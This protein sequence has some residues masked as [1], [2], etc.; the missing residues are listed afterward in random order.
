MKNLWPL[1]CISPWVH[2]A[3]TV[4]SCTSAAIATP[5]VP[6]ALITNLTAD[7]VNN[8][9]ISITGESN[10]W[11]AQ[12]ITVWLP[13]TGWNGIFLGVG[14]GGFLAGSPSSLAPAVQ[15]GYAAVS[16]DAGHRSNSTSNA[17][18]W[19]LVSNG[20]VN[21]Y[22]LLDFGSRSVHDMTV[23][24]KAV[25]TSFYGSAPN[26]SYWQGCS[27][28][29]RQG[30]MEAQRYPD[31]YDGIVA[32]APAIQWNDLQAAQQWPFTVMINEGYA[33][34]QC[35]FDAVNAA[36]IAACDGL[37][38]LEDGII[39]APGLCDFNPASLVG[40]TYTCDSDGSQRQFS[41]KTATVV[42]KI[43]QGP[44]TANG[45]N[46]WYGILP[47]TNFSSLAPTETFANGTTIPQPFAISDNWYRNFLFKDPNY[48]TSNIT[49]GQFP[50][51][52]HQSHQE[53]DSVIGTADP[54]LSAYKAR[55]GKILT[56]QGLADY[57]IMPNGTMHYYD[58]VAALD[59]MVTDFYRV[60]FAPGVG[61]CGGGFGYVPV[62][63][64]TAL[65]RWVE[66]GTAPGVLAAATSFAVNGTIRTQNLCPY[67]SVS[68]YIG[69]GDPAQAASF[70]CESSF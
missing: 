51:L 15:R 49:Y 36:A 21:Q 11:P 56:W 29:G 47:G 16:T 24:G 52:T 33:P 57:L 58:Q 45:S 2:A 61:H 38:G 39:A 17:T 63:I 54:D 20:N 37:D 46:A 59:P 18:S 12:N 66:N 43:W 31:D 41:N 13:L 44:V 26:Y 34:P 32:G 50:A 6:G 4:D 35:E 42:E 53:Y 40:K 9:S 60:F 62:D 69:S 14:G 7:V 23:L 28:G 10:N 64:L 48:N 27:T 30:M 70:T 25:T 67:P 5:V 65:R 19:A 1:L 22:L 55:G 3:A 8:Y 68:K